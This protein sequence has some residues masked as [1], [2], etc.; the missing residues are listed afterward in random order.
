MCVCVYIYMHTREQWAAV[1]RSVGF[2][3]L[4]TVLRRKMQ[5]KVFSAAT[6]LI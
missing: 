1:G 2:G 3:A 5:A 4:L 6:V